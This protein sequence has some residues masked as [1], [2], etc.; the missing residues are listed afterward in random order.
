MDSVAAVACMRYQSCDR[1]AGMRGDWCQQFLVLGT[2]SRQQTLS[3]LLMV[4]HT[5]LLPLSASAFGLMA[6]TKKLLLAVEK[7]VARV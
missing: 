5:T 4:D 6:G 1:A 2:C 3:G 7:A